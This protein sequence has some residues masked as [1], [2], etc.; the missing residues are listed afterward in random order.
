MEIADLGISDALFFAATTTATSASPHR[1]H[2][3]LKKSFI[4]RKSLG[5]QPYP[6]NGQQQRPVS[7]YRFH[8]NRK[9]QS[10]VQDCFHIYCMH[11]ITVNSFAY[12]EIST[13]IHPSLFRLFS[14][15]ISQSK[16]NPKGAQL[17][18]TTHVHRLPNHNTMRAD[19]IWFAERPAAT[20]NFS[21]FGIFECFYQ[22]SFNGI[23]RAFRLPCRGIRFY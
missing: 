16:I 4:G 15:P 20:P 1:F 5:I 2:P 10:L 19:Q 14:K 11:W 17:V 3:K 9:Q 6:Q 23:V 8:L 12:D 22:R 7:I 21:T 18:F 13:A